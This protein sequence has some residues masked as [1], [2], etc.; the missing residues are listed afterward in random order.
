MTLGFTESKVDS[1]L[2][3]KGVRWKTSDALV[4]CRCTIFLGMEVWNNVD[5]IFLG[6]RKYVVEI[7]KRF[8]MIDW[9]ALTTPMASNMKLLS[10]ASSETVDATMYRQMIGSLM[11][12]RL[13][14]C[15]VVNKLRHVHLMVEKHA[16][17]QLIMD[18]STIRIKRLTWRVTLIHIGQEVP[19]T[20]RVLQD[21]ASVWDQV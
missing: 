18:S 9:K 14:T 19:S 3:F 15:L 5:G 10:D 2:C 8:R 7:L 11:Y 16:G 17:V 4:M 6:Q 20:G 13:D 21:V 12:P 1:N